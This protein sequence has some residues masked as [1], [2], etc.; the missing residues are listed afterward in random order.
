MG[1]K[2][3]RIGVLVFL[4]LVVILAYATA[5]ALYGRTVVTWWIPWAACGAMGLFSGLT[6]WR[7]WVPLTDEAG[8]W[9]NYLAHAVTATGIIACLF[10]GANYACADTDAIYEETVTVER[11]YREEHHRTQRV[12]RR[13]YRRVGSPWYD[14]HIDI[15]FSDGRTKRLTVPLKRYNRLRTGSDT[16]IRLAPGLFK[17]PVIR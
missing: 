14:Y 12:G 17:I 15:R 1:N 8:F 3:L 9:L 6:M 7:L 16:T 4:I 5:I 2:K 13:H 11:K 10:F